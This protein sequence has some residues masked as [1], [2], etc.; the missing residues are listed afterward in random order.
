MLSD[1][2]QTLTA[3]HADVYLRGDAAG[4]ID[5][6]AAE[7]RR[8]LR[9]LSGKLVDPVSDGDIRAAADRAKRAVRAHANRPVVAGRIGMAG[10]TDG[11]SSVGRWVR[12]PLT[13]AAALVAGLVL[14]LFFATSQSKNGGLARGTDVAIPEGSRGTLSSSVVNPPTPVSTLGDDRADRIVARYDALFAPTAFDEADDDLAAALAWLDAPDAAI[15]T[16]SLDRAE[17]ADDEA[18]EDDAGIDWASVLIN[19]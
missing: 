7:L 5:P 19:G 1:D 14:T 3:A 18:V 10:E 13:A 12:W 16:I 2:D 8:E 15:S 6:E 4:P 11:S 17:P 9:D